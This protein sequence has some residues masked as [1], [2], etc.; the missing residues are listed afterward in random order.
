MKTFPMKIKIDNLKYILLIFS[1]IIVPLNNISEILALFTMT[2]KSQSEAL[3]PFFIKILKDAVYIFFFIYGFYY[4]FKTQKIDRIILFLALL[5]LFVILPLNTTLLLGDTDF[6]QLLIGIRFSLPLLIIFLSFYIFNKNDILKIK[7]LLFILFYLN[8]GIQIVQFFMGIPLYGI[9]DTLGF[10]IRN[11]GFFLLPNTS[12]FFII[13]I[14]YLV[15]Y[16]FDIKEK[17]KIRF[18]FFSFLSILLTASGTGI[19]VFLILNIIYFTKKIL[20]LIFLILSP[21]FLYLTLNLVEYIRDTEYI[22]ISGSTRLK[23]LMDM[24]NSASLISSDFGKFTNAYV[25]LR[26][27]GDIMDS[28]WAA[29]LGNYGFLPSVILVLILIF[30]FI[31]SLINLDKS[32]ISFL[33]IILSFSSTTII[34]EA[35][36]MNILLS[37]VFPSAFK[38]KILLNQ[39]RYTYENSLQRS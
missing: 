23:I 31:Y 35:Y 1:L 36:P 15:L 20:L 37:I 38:I 33:I 34:F 10:S 19:F 13:I 8:L 16:H 25:L 27:D 12:A 17:I 28:T 3:T 30:L 9:Y 26:G 11:P 39:P 6:A 14:T 32:K 21:I 2:L 4:L 29:L 24:F 22:S 7:N 5:F 18:I